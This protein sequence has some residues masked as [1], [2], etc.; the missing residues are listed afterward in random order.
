VSE[1]TC[2]G[3]GQEVEWQERRHADGALYSVCPN[4]GRRCAL[5][6]QLGGRGLYGEQRRE[7]RDLW[8]R[9][10]VALHAA[11][12]REGGALDMDIAKAQSRGLRLL[13]VE[14]SSLRKRITGLA[15][16]TD[17]VLRLGVPRKA[18]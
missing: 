6:K 7:E 8:E 13:V 18:A 11:L 2:K 5:P 15:T 16:R 3:C 9:E 1:A 10:L 14:L 12:L 4:C 17:T